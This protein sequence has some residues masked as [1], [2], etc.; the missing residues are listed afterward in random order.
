MEQ[1]VFIAQ[2]VD[3]LGL[4]VFFIGQRRTVKNFLDFCGIQFAVGGDAIDHGL[5]QVVDKGLGR[6]TVGRGHAFLCKSVGRR[7][8]VAN[9]ENFG[10]H[11][12]LGEGVLQEERLG[13]DAAEREHAALEQD[14]LVGKGGEVVFFQATVDDEGRHRLLAGGEFPDQ[15]SDLLH[16]GEAGFH[17]LYPQQHALD[18]FIA[19]GP[20]Q[21]VPEV[22][23]GNDVVPPG[24]E[25]SRGGLGDGPSQF[26]LQVG[27]LW[28]IRLLG[29]LQVDEPPQYENAQQDDNDH[30]Q[31]DQRASFHNESPYLFS[32]ATRKD[33]YTVFCAAKFRSGTSGS[34]RPRSG[35]D[36][37]AMKGI[38]GQ[39][40]Q[41]GPAADRQADQ[42]GML[43]E[44]KQ[45]HGNGEGDLEV[46]Q[47]G[48]RSGGNTGRADVPKI[49]TYSGGQQSQVEQNQDLDFLPG[50]SPAL[51]GRRAWPA[52][53]TP[54][55]PGR[56]RRR[57]RDPANPGQRRT[58]G[59]TRAD[60]RQSRRWRPGQGKSPTNRPASPPSRVYD[61]RR[62]GYGQ[63]R[64]P[65]VKRPEAPFQRIVEGSH[66]QRGEDG[67]QDHL[68]GG[69]EME[70][71]DVEDVHQA[72]LDHAD[73][74]QA[75]RHGAGNWR[76]RQK[77]RKGATQG[78]NAAKATKPASTS[79]RYFLIKP[80]EKAQ[81]NEVISNS[82]MG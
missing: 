13:T 80:N 1:V 62:A 7:L 31:G 24:E 58:A 8:V 46:V 75:Q 41:N 42:V 5:V 48:Q 37:P 20:L 14:D 61:H 36:R 50:A 33:H 44:K 22:M 47:H 49:K 17:V 79:P 30:Q 60:R 51:P 52:P 35:R 67:E 69:Q 55:P 76:G 2:G 10:L 74:Q 59:G 65:E 68:V 72:E 19:G 64:R 26:D 15:A 77:G 18:A 43:L 53:P 82:A 39:G 21:L 4:D 54:L 6:L 9:M 25:A 29:E 45:G 40:Q 32:A 70:G 81:M 78:P 56:A 38:Q 3:Q 23:N 63:Q 73:A 66:V 27:L 28:D 12:Q 11:A 71:L 57:R 16:L 34:Q